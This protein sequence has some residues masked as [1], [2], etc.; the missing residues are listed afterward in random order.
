MHLLNKWGY[1]AFLCGSPSATQKYYT[2]LIEK[3]L[4]YLKNAKLV[5]HISSYLYI[6]F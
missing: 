5:I 4:L 3:I 6:L 1:V 2:P